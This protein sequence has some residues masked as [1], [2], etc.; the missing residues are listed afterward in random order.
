MRLIDPV[1]YLEFQ[2][3]ISSAR[4]VLTDSGGIQEETTA[5][6]VPCMTLRTNTERPVTVSHGTN[7]L[8]GM[9]PDVIVATYRESISQERKT[10][11]PPLWDGHA[12]KRIVKII[13]ERYG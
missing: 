10:L 9:D 8:V 6:G 11:M 5:L 2:Q 4:I 1:G 13:M 3:L 7:Q 12:A